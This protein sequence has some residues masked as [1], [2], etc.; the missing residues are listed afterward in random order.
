MIS[1]SRVA[2]ASGTGTT[3]HRHLLEQFSRQKG[4]WN[5]PQKK[6]KSRTSSKGFNFLGQNVRKYNG[7]LLIKPSQQKHQNVSGKNAGNH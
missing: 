2:V 1:L 7:K 3:G 6:P 5:F 4:G